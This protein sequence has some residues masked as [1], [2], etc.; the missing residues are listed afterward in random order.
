MLPE[1]AD[2]Q[3]LGL[4]LPEDLLQLPFHYSQAS[5][6]L[7]DMGA[8]DSLVTHDTHTPKFFVITSMTD[9][10]VSAKADML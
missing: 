8:K 10:V 9:P 1:V 5:V 3:L 2:H 7:P 4:D 6:V